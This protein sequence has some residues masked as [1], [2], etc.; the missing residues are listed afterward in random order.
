MSVKISLDTVLVGRYYIDPLVT[1]D[2]P[3]HE[4]A[5][6]LMRF[7]NWEQTLDSECVSG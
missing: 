4:P 5:G 6:S 3:G 2:Q 7:R 1:R